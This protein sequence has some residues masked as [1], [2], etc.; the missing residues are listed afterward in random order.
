LPPLPS[1]LA[2]LVRNATVTNVSVPVLIA[3]SLRQAI[4]LGVIKGGEQLRQSDIARQFGVSAIPVRE[5]FQQLVAEGFVEGH[6]NKGVVVAET[7][8]DE[9]HELFDLRV[10]LESILLRKA[11]PAMDAETF[12]RAK[13]H[14]ARLEG[15]TDTTRWG[16]WNWMFHQ[17]LYLPAQRPRTLKVVANVNLHIDRLLRV[18]MTLSAGAQA[19]GKEH[20]AIL[21]ACE[22]RDTMRALKLLKEHIR[23]VES[24]LISFAVHAG[25]IHGKPPAKG[26]AGANASATIAQP[27]VTPSARNA[28]LRKASAR[29]SSSARIL[30][31]RV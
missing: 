25:L 2:E 26:R 11:I 31:G 22:K 13:D 4:I 15:E 7:S 21:K 3:N 24:I 14:Q 6:R 18:Q 29:S 28:P 10:A 16:H 17:T 9:I 20:H 12:S 23:G 1:S 19:T 5:A 27:S 8:T 30:P